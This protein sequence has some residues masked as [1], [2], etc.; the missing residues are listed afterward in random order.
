MLVHLKGQRGGEGHVQPVVAERRG[1][2]GGAVGSGGTQ[3][4]AGEAAYVFTIGVAHGGIFA[5]TVLPF[6][7][8][9]V[10]DVPLGRDVPV[11]RGVEGEFVFVAL[12]ILRGVLVE[13]VVRGVAVVV[14]LVGGGAVEHAGRGL[15]GVVVHGGAR[16]VVR[17]VVPLVQAHT[18]RVALALALQFGGEEGFVDA[19]AV[20]ARHAALHVASVGG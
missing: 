8:C 15:H 19:A 3:V 11:V 13:V 6:Q 7:A 9:A 18:P 17:V 2:N 20:E 14:R 10:V 16:S 4:V 12:V 1:G 5:L